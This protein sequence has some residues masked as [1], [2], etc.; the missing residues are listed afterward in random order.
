MDLLLGLSND[1]DIYLGAGDNETQVKFFKYL[2]APH[3]TVGSMAS[4]F[5]S[6]F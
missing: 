1:E 2:T 6:L 5:G 3:K 4:P